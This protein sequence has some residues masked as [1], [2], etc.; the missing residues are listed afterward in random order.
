MAGRRGS[1]ALA[2]AFALASVFLT[3]VGTASALG[4]PITNLAPADGTAFE[5]ATRSSQVVAVEFTCPSFQTTYLGVKDWTSYYVEFATSPEL[6]P[7]GTLATAFTVGIDR[8]FPTNAA[9]TTC[10]AESSNAIASTPGTYYWQVHR[11][12]CDA[13][14]CTE[15]G[16]VWTFTIA[17]PPSSGPVGGGDGSARGRPTAFIACGLTVRAPRRATCR[18]PRKVGAFFRSPFDTRYS[19]CVTYPNRRRLCARN[20]FARAGVLYVN[21]IT[22]NMVG[23]MKVVWRAGRFRIVRFFWRI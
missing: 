16:P 14:D 2:V 3:T 8:A 15:T 7:D 22:T 21:R 12:N 4:P 10:R 18:R 5:R 23:R 17:N 6:G 13:I 20:Q 11:I 19:V 9:E 1:R